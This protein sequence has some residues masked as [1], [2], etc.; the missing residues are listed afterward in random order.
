[1]LGKWWYSGAL[2]NACPLEDAVEARGAKAVLVDLPETGLE[3]LG[4][5]QV[6]VPF[7]SHVEIA[8]EE[9]FLGQGR[10][11]INSPIIPTGM[12][13]VNPSLHWPG[14]GCHAPVPRWTASRV[15]A[16]S[17][18]RSPLARAVSITRSTPPRDRA[19]T[20]TAFGSDFV[21]DQK[22][23]GDGTAGRAYQAVV[24]TYPL[25][26]ML[27]YHNA[28]KMTALMQTSDGL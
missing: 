7:R 14:G 5:G 1:M 2:G 13:D 20:I 16:T 10:V 18:S 4:A 24:C 25:L 27:R 3:Q 17:G 6:G 8:C 22:L 23:F 9:P 15:V 21:D 12:Y 26:D 11:W 28:R 19:S